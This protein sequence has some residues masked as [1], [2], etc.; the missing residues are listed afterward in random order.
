MNDKSVKDALYLYIILK[1]HIVCPTVTI[2]I[3][4]VAVSCGYD[5][6]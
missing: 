2:I 3:L 4:I 6:W 1:C 5:T